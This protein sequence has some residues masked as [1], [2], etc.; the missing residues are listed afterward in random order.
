LGSRS[1]SEVDWCAFLPPESAKRNQLHFAWP[2][3]QKLRGFLTAFPSGD[4]MKI[5]SGLSTS[6]R[7]SL[8]TIFGRACRLGAIISLFAAILFGHGQE[9]EQGLRRDLGEF[10]LTLVGD[11]NI[12]TLATARQ[13][14]P[15]FMAAV[16]EIRKG[17]AAFNNLE[18]TFPGPDAY[19]GGAPRSE[20]IFSDPSLLKELQWMGFN[21]FGTANNHS[22]DYGI[23]GLL[24]TIQVLRQG[25]AVYAGTGVDL[26]HARA[27]GYLS[28]PHGRVALITCA[29]TFPEDS[30]AGQARPDI[31]GRPGLSPLHYDVRYHVNTEDFESLVRLNDHLTL[32]G[33]R[34]GIAP[35]QTINFVFPPSGPSGN[36]GT[37]V[38]FETS[39][40]PGVVTTPSKN[41]LDAL[42]RSIRDARFFADYVVASIHAHEGIPGQSAG[43]VEVP[44]QFVI[45]Y[46]HAAIDAGADVF[47]GSGPHVLQGIEIYKGK[48]ILYNLG[49]FITENWIMQPEA[50]TMYDRFNL[51]LDALPSEAHN[52]RSD[53]G[54]KDEPSYPLYW[55][56]AIARV[57]FRGGR[58]SEVNLT[59]ISL[60][61]KYR[62]VD[63]GWPEIA[64]L[65]EATEILQRLQRLSNP[66]GTKIS[67]INGEGTITIPQ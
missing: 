26:G 21:L 45:E 13:N 14:N 27:P 32:M 61:Y 54:R 15:R 59:P 30:P 66:Y 6:I 36:Y 37:H 53:Y 57:V 23:Q 22:M 60:G 18:T 17:D 8:S 7:F 51:G 19:P 10:N 20:N 48:V 43:H 25:G 63:R 11:N 33:V 34:G 49:N 5:R 42:T 39:E 31:R 9:Q 3:H 35:S 46:A 58:P 12:V 24:D 40:K 56:T 50:S 41:D 28:T 38:I 4:D 67:V 44:A 64:D 62:S 2:R 55:Q 29:S 16:G 52:A 1:F 47:V 65:P